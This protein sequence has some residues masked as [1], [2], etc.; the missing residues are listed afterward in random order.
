MAKFSAILPDKEIQDFEKIYKN[1]EK[2]FGGMTR[3]GAQTVLNNVKASAPLPA[4]AS[5][6]KLSVTYRTPTN[7]RINTKVY[8]SGYLPF[9][10]NRKT[11]KRRGRKGSD[12]YTTTKGVPVAF[13]ATLYEY[14]R[15]SAPFP[16]K[17]FLRTSFRKNQIESA[18]LK[19]QN[20]LSGGLL[21]E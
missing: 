13:L 7:G 20:E 8:L 18:M 4:M 6:A 11:F 1:T 15:T 5:K 3:A 21:G 9:K 14:G 2:I 12:V 10:G 19:A 17:P 16:Y